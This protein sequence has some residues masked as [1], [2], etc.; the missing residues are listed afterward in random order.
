MNLL[1]L[2]KQVGQIDWIIESKS[3]FKSTIWKPNKDIVLWL[4]PTIYY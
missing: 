3:Q 1:S 2:L 4:G